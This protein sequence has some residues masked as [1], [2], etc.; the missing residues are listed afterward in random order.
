MNWSRYN[1]LF[2]SERF[3]YFLYNSL[4]NKLHELDQEHY[5][6]L[7]HFRDGDSDSGITADSDFDT[8][9]RKNKAIVDNGEEKRLLL[10]RQYE[11]HALCFDSNHLGLTI[12]PTLQCNF[13]C[14]YCFENSQ[15]DSTAMSPE[16]VAQLINF[17]TSYKEIHHLS[18]AWYGG[19]PLLAFAIIKDITER[20]QALPINFEGAGL[21]TN[22][23]L[24]DEHIIAQL[25]NL[26]INSIQIT[27]DGPE[28][29]HDSRRIHKGGGPTYQRILTN[30]DNLMNSTYKGTCAIRVNIDKYNQDRFFTLRDTLQERFK[31]KKLT[32]YAGHVNTG[33]DHPYGHNCSLD[34]QE[35]T[36]FTFAMHRKSG[37]DPKGGFFPS[38]NL[39]SICVATTHNGFVV[40]PE[41][42]LYKCWEDVGKPDMVIGTINNDDPITNPALRA[43]YSIGTDAYNDPD[44]SLC[45]VLPICG[46]GCANKRFRTKERDEKGLEFCSPYKDNLITY[47][48]E[49]IN[50][51]RSKEICRSVLN[52]GFQTTIN[53]GYRDISPEKKKPAENLRPGITAINA[54]K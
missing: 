24:L 41:G 18:L 8:Y 39:H 45:N 37:K 12:C 48:E 10:A 43:A 22:G 1:T 19:E 2:H 42:E 17:I 27:L 26:N 53:K 5:N 35:W 36:N 7:Q 28:E 16:N 46:G 21:V 51:F 29:V 11:R 52:P 15:K 44:C 50:A 40:G 30:V 31:G 20:I 49:Y 33:I 13:R 3:G 25:N 47:L 23:Y 9:L 14:P 32:V 4:I 6:T 34:L 54:F 38:G